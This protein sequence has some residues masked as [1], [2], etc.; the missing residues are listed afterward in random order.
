ML[1]NNNFATNNNRAWEIE[2]MTGGKKKWAQGFRARLIQH[3]IA[4]MEGKLI[5]DK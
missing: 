1:I 3:E 2:Y 5:C 4:H